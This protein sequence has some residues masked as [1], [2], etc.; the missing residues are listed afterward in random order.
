[1]LPRTE[2]KKKETTNLVLQME[3]RQFVALS[4]MDGSQREKVYQQAEPLKTGSD[5]QRLCFVV[6]AGEL[7]GPKEARKQLQELGAPPNDAQVAE[8]LDK[9]YRDYDDEKYAAP[10]LSAEER[11]LLHNKLGWF[12]DL[13]LN[14]DQT[15]DRAA[16]AAVLAPAQKSLVV[17]IGMGA[18]FIALG[19]LGFN[20]LVVLTI[21]ALQGKVR[22]RFTTGSGNGPIYAETFAIWMLLFAVLSIAGQFVP[23]GQFRLLGAGLASLVS[24]SALSWPVFRGIP[25]RTVREETGLVWKAGSP[26]RRTPSQSEQT[27]VEAYPQAWETDPSPAPSPSRTPAILEPIYGMAAYIATLPLMFVGVLITF[28]LMKLQQKLFGEGGPFGIGNDP[29]HP[30]AGILL[31]ANWWG[32]LQVILAASVFAPILEETMF[33]GVLYRHLREA[34][35]KWSRFWSV[36]A[37]AA[38][39][40]FIFA[41]IH[42]QGILAVPALMA[43]AIGFSIAREWRGTLIPAMVAHGI[44]NGMVTVL[45]L[46]SMG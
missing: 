7:M 5:E 35:G 36:L 41:V 1:M 19:F 27:G 16:R 29:S 20:L 22:F 3:A 21:L 45:L 2:E 13:A 37:S 10:S 26:I 9:L 18:G 32:R 4:H 28:G 34:T 30:I 43:L 23:L 46:V 39:V 8:L 17:M 6:L 40:S 44:N 11:G 33:R 38:V 31:T 25:W 24:L 42:P 14:P 12:G 15:P